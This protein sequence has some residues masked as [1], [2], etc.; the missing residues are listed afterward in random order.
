[1]TVTEINRGIESLSPEDRTKVRA[2]LVHLER[3]TNPSYLESLDRKI[4]RMKA[5]YGVSATDLQQL[6]TILT[7][8][9]E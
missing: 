5:G 2:F 9:G 6:D 8:A 1:M 4:E 3:G 7:K